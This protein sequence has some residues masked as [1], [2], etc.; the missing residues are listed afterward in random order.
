MA[1]IKLELSIEEVDYI[2]TALS[3]QP[4]VEVADIITKIQEQ[5]RPQ[6]EVIDKEVENG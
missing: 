2:L 6:V 1:D 5:G 4:F 3:K